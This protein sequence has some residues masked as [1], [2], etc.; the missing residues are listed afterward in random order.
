MSYIYELHHTILKIN[1]IMPDDHVCTSVATRLI[2]KAPYDMTNLEVAYIA[3]IGLKYLD[4]NENR[5]GVEFKE[6]ISAHSLEDLIEACRKWSI[7]FKKE[8]EQSNVD[9]SIPRHNEI[10]S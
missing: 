2:N 8:N 10:K 3:C 6:G 1:Y 9:K 5:I 7:A 4:E